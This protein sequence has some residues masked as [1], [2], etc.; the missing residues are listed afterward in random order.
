MKKISVFICFV[1]LFFLSSCYSVKQTYSGNIHQKSVGL[2]KNQAL[3]EYGVPDRTED[4]GDGGS[5]LV[6][7]K[8]VE[9][10]VSS[11]KFNTKGR[12]SSE[13]GVLY[14]NGGILGAGQ[15]RNTSRG[16]ARSTS[17]KS[18]DKDFLNVF[19]NKENVVYDFKSNYGALYEKSEC[20]DKTTTWVGVVC[21]GVFFVVPML[22]T[23]P[24]AI[25][26]QRKA[27]KAGNIC[28]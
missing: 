25:V 11:A 1:F 26:K 20:F 19:I 16:S 17:R 6:Y 13:A 23:I 9:T 10:T 7:E 21:S 5:V 18:V 14:G 8:F 2:T 27:K 28:K 12:N 15:G 4:D 3:R 22:V 24:L